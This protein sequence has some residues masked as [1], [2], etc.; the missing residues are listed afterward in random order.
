MGLGVV[1]FFIGFEVDVGW[2]VCFVVIG[3][4]VG[5]ILIND[6]LDFV[7]VVGFLLC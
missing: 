2:V 4:G 3:V 7:G 6:G 5:L 1:F